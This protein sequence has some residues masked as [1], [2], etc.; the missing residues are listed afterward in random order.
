MLV[1]TGFAWESFVWAALK[2][3]LWLFWSWIGFGVFVAGWEDFVFREFGRFDPPVGQDRD[4]VKWLEKNLKVK[5]LPS[6]EL[7]D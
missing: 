5:V 3:N 2:G 1:E 7:S 4:H 6:A